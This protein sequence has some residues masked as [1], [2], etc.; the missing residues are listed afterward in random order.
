MLV[1]FTVL[2]S[3]PTL[4]QTKGSTFISHVDRAKGTPHRAT[5]LSG[6]EEDSLVNYLRYLSE[7]ALPVT[8]RM[9]IAFCKMVAVK[10]VNL[11]SLGP[12]VRPKGGLRNSIHA[13]EIN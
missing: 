9:A 13:T 11:T 4:S 8:R 3:H 12:M 7:R 1:I 2:Y 6:E 5:V 10:L